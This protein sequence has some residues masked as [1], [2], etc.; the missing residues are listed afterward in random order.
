[1]TYRAVLIGCGNI[2]SMYADDPKIKGIYTHAEAYLACPKTEL[3]A[4]CDIDEQKAAT[5]AKKWGITNYY[6]NIDQLLAEQNPEIVSICTSDKSH[7]D[8]LD[9]V[10]KSSRLKGVIAEKPLTLNENQAMELVSRARQNRVCLAV[11]YNR[12]YS[13][14]H[15][16]L[17]DDIQAGC[18]GKIQKITGFYTKG[19]LHNGTHWIDLARWL[20]GEI[21]ELQGFSTR[22]QLILDDPTLDAWFKF[23]NN[24]VGFL[25]GLDAKLYSLFEMDI[26][27]TDGR[28]RI[29]NSGHEIEYYHVVDSTYYSGYK[30]LQKINVVEDQVSDTLLHVVSNLVDAI[31][32]S[33]I[34]RCS[35][36]DGV[37]ALY[38]A[39]AL[40]KSA[41]IGSKLDVEYKQY[42]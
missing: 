9:I 16:K 24:T 5:C 2:G 18:L 17:R 21:C 41:Q 40:V 3:V 1:M 23:E 15:Q 38:I 25:Q 33:V 28:V 26:T 37:K 32:G 39:N 6:T 19:I 10:L 22:E 35:G 13:P 4:V 36:T 20:F 14:G 7:A 42:E 29:I 27:G 11:N 30:T 8:V 34:P 12:R 31:E